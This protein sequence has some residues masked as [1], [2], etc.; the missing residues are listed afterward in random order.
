VEAW[1][2]EE[3]AAAAGADTEPGAGTGADGSYSAAGP[4]EALTGDRHTLTLLKS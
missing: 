4:S 3:R 2:V 1:E